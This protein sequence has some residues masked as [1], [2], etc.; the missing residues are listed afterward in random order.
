MTTTTATKR[1]YLLKR[2]RERMTDILKNDIFG[3]FESFLYDYYPDFSWK[4]P[5][6]VEE[7]EIIVNDPAW[8]TLAEQIKAARGYDFATEVRNA[9]E[10][11]KAEAAIEA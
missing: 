1:P 8:L 7:L 4:P 3:T 10:H 2:E 5:E 6:M 9:I 11:L